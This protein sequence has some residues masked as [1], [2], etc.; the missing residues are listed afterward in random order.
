MAAGPSPAGDVGGNGCVRS[1]VTVVVTTH[2]GAEVIGRCLDSLIE[3]TVAPDRI[4]VVDDGSTDGTVD[5]VEARARRRPGL[6]TVVSQPNRGVAAALRRGVAEADTEFV[7]IAD[8]DDRS[9]P[10]R[11]EFSVEL[12]RR[13]GADMV[14][15]QVTGRL[16]GRLR[17][18]TSRFA[19]DADAISA[20][21]SA[22]LDPLPHTTMMVRRDGFGRFGNYRSLQRVA[23]VELMLRW[24]HR[25][26]RIAVSP[27]VL[28]E[29]SYRPEFFSFDTAMR[30]MVLT[31]YA[32]AIATLPD[33]EV[34]DFA[35]WFAREPLGPVRREAIVRVLR[36]TAR[37]GVGM[38]RR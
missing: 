7:A 27:A 6:F 8:H 28:A 2:D 9:A 29:Y 21:V 15:G 33:D 36:L 17:L 30:W 25:G 31:R 12:L 16:G 35:V 19:T 4:V 34:P 18:A 5:V 26:A 32:R 20:R 37:L 22:G 23:D 1:G 10:R 24:A 13:T 3:Q 38:V 11:L 14:G